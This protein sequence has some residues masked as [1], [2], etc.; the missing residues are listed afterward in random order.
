MKQIRQYLS[1]YNLF[2]TSSSTVH[3][4]RREI[5][6]TRIYLILLITSTIILVFYTGL[7]ERTK[8][9]TILSPSQSI[10][11]YLQRTY[12][13]TLQCPCSNISVSYSNF[14]IHLNVTFHPVCSSDLVAEQWFTSLYL[15]GAGL[16]WWIRLQDFRKWGTSYFQ[17]LQSFCLLTNSTVPM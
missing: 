4:R 16:A 15:Y 12:S 10:Y 9:G 7:I 1:T 3:T 2:E 8:S 11:E 13:N 17:S 14:T 5:L 6:S